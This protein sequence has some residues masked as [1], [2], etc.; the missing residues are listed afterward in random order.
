M[1]NETGTVVI[2]NTWGSV[3]QNCVAGRP[4]LHLNHSVSKQTAQQRNG[5]GPETRG[6]TKERDRIEREI[7]IQ[8][9]P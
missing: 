1:G 6:A 3:F 4:P 7:T 5:K 2:E 9:V 8:Q